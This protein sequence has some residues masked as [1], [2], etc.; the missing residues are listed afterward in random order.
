MTP[1]YHLKRYN[2]LLVQK[3]T[4]ESNIITAQGMLDSALQESNMLEALSSSLKLAKPLLQANSITQVQDLLTSALSSVFDLPH[5]V[6]WDP[7]SKE[8]VIQYPDGDVPLV[9][10]SGGGVVTV[11]S[12]VLD[13]FLICKD[14]CRKLLIY[15]EAWTAVSEEYV[16]RFYAFIRKS[17]K[18]LGVDIL[19][20]THD[21]RVLNEWVDHLYVVGNHTATKVK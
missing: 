11:L 2:D 8:F 5:K 1:E 16:E 6:I 17:C 3:S 20:V 7:E 18:D 15:D 12:A 19:L 9:G 13:L 4:F 10:S 21:A 14:G